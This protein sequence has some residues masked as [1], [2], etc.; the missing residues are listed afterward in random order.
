MTEI[1]ARRLE[2]LADVADQLP[3]RYRVAAFQELVRHELSP[4]A[5]R[6]KDAEPRNAG[7]SGETEVDTPAWFDGVLAEVPELHQ[8]PT[9]GRGAEAAWA[10]I[11]LF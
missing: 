2:E 4:T 5:R 8:I 3:D 6:D 7:Q 11:D 10:V 9:L 1:I